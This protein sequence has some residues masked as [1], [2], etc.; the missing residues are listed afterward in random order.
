MFLRPDNSEIYIGGVTADEIN[1]YTISGSRRVST[2]TIT[3]DVKVES[4]DF[5]FK[6]TSYLK[7]SSSL[8]LSPK[9]DVNIN[10]TI[11]RS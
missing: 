5:D 6:D 7:I 11:I 2:T 10:F 8:E 4:S 9:A 3:G 1:V